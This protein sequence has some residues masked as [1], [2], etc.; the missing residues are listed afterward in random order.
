MVLLALLVHGVGAQTLD[1]ELQ[2]WILVVTP[3]NLTGNAALDPLGLAVADSVE[4]TLNL[5][6]SYRI[7][8]RLQEEQVPGTQHMWKLGISAVALV[9]VLGGCG[10]FQSA[11]DQLILDDQWTLSEIKAGSVVT[12]DLNDYLSVTFDATND[13]V[14]YQTGSAWPSAIDVDG[15]FDYVIDGGNNTILLSESGT[16]RYTIVYEFDSDLGE[17]T[18]TSWTVEGS[19]AE[20]VG[21]S[22][23]LDYI[24]F[25]RQ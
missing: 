4:L 2:P 21:E 15:T 16:A 22:G 13:Q 9:L 11:A 5:L 1:D 25:D 7:Q 14:T 18:W 12:T 19:G 6:G 23:A 17:M 10:A 8:P 20:I 3:A 24:K